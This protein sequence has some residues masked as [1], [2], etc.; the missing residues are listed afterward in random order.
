MIGVTFQSGEDLLRGSLH[1]PA[2]PEQRVPGVLILPGFADTAVGPHNL[3][4]CMARVLAQAGYAVLRFDYAGLGESEGDFRAFT[5]L[6]GLK[7][8]QAA[9]RVLQTRP[10]VDASRLGVIG[11]S[12]GGALACE[13]AARVDAIQVLALLAPVTYASKVFRAFFSAEHLRQGEE[14]GWIDWLGWP[15]G[16]GYLASLAAL[17]PLAALER[18]RATTLVLHGTRDVEVAGENAQAYAQRG[19]ALHWL[20][21][22]DHQFSSVA[23]Q[24][25]AIHRVRDW[26]Q[27]RFSL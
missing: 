25:E 12:L 4:V 23:L 27:R 17:D 24:D 2:N 3:H 9:L 8:A 16:A 20:E 10:E 1:L 15:V 19:A 14:Q 11:F 7:N 26:L 22:G 5:A 6:S 13:L 21:G 18:S